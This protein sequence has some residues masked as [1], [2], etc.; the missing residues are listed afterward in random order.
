VGWPEGSEKAIGVSPRG[1]ED[2]TDKWGPVVKET[3]ERR[4]AREGVIRKGKR[5]FCEDATDAWAGLA[6]QDDFGLR[7]RRGRWA[8]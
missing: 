2:T 7:G 3:R 5:I 1:G 8:G 6:G 4:P